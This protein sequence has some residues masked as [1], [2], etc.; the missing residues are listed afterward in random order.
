MDTS[1]VGPWI[2][3][4]H[5]QGLGGAAKL[6]LLQHVDSPADAFDATDQQ[7]QAAGLTQ[8]QCDALRVA[9][10]CD[11]LAGLVDTTQRWLEDPQHHCITLGSPLYPQALASIT[12][13]PLVL[14]VCGDTD[15]L[16]RPGVGIVGS[17]QSAPPTLTSTGEIAGKLASAGLV[18]TSGMAL[19]VDQAAHHAALDADGLTMAIAG[20]GLDRVYPARHRQLARAI[21][22][23]GA[24]VSE[25]ALGA[26]PQP[27][28]FP[29]RN[30]IISGL[31]L[32]VVVV[33]ATLKSG[34]LTTAKHAMEQGREVMVLPGSINN[35]LSRGCHA[36][37]KSGATLVESA[38]DILAE[39]AP[40][41]DTTTLKTAGSSRQ[42]QQT[43]PANCD[44]HRVLLDSMGY[45]A[46]GV[47]TLAER[48]TEPV[49]SVLAA[50]VT[51]ELSGDVARTPGGRYIRC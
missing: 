10:R 38:E 19:G 48:L 37:I 46:I 50:L 22:E 31:S 8:P 14:Y 6:R 49:A 3:L 16:S 39:I 25:F 51:L 17:R 34:T 29:R 1:D 43:R 20:T 30:R 40:Q 44:D 21:A 24:L 26:S 7:L 45:D 23:Q 18:I 47:D 12:T 5:G 11:T 33:E 2:R 9:G 27:H 41:I 36:L 35:P 28:H 13:P 15:L 4:A 42:T 32:G